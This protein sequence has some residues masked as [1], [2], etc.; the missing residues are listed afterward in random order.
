MSKGKIFQIIWFQ[1]SISAW[2]EEDIQ[3]THFI[4]IIKQFYIQKY[5][6]KVSQGNMS[7]GKMSQGKIFF[8]E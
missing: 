3:K 7:Q 4:S 1:M 2:K 8:Q 6:Q 5:F